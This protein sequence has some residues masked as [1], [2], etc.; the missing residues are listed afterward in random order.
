MPVVII[1]SGA[2]GFDANAVIDAEG[3]RAFFERGYRFAVRY[4]PRVQSRPNDLSAAEIQDLTDAGLA[5]MPV[6]HVESESSW[7]PSG[8]KGARYGDTAAAACR[9]VGLPHGVT[10]WCDL[11]GV[12][13]GTSHAVVI[14]HCNAWFDSVRAAGYQPGLYVGWHSGLTSDELYH[15]LR[16][17]RYWAAYNLNADQ[18]PAVRGVQMR[19]HSATHA[20][21]PAGIL[22]EID[23][24]T[25]RADRLGALPTAFAANGWAP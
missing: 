3:A 7:V 14:R 4:V 12:K 5:V 21:V 1:P 8:A 18:E 16:F 20:D 13:A 17:E 19:Q 9:E 15:K 24:D 10:V 23:T 22:F 11:E 6:Q 2:R 25:V